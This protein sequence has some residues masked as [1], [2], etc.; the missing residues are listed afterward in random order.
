MGGSGDN[1]KKNRKKEKKCEGKWENRIEYLIEGKRNEREI[2][3]RYEIGRKKREGVAERVEKRG[4]RK[5][6][7]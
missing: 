4:R 3:N 2:G 1:K 7:K 5:Q 6:Y